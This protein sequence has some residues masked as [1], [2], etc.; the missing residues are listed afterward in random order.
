MDPDTRDDRPSLLVRIL[1]PIAFFWV[2]SCGVAWIASGAKNYPDRFSES[3]LWGGV[4][5]APAVTVALYLFV[6]LVRRLIRGRASSWGALFFSSGAVFGGLAMNLVLFSFYLDRVFPPFYSHGRRLHH[7]AKILAAS[8]QAGA[9]W[10]GSQAIALDVEDGERDAVAAQWRENGSKEHASIAA[11]AHVT[12]DLMAVGAPA[13]IIAAAQ[14]AALDE[15]R[16]AEACYAVA[17]A[18]DGREESPAPFPEAHVRR[19]LAKARPVALAQIAVDALAD[20]ALNEGIA[21]RILARLA[22]RAGTPEL[23][24]LLAQTA[25]DEARHARD[26]WDVIEWCVAEGGDLVRYALARAKEAMPAHLGSPLPPAARSGAWEAWGVQGVSLE[27]AEYAIV[28]RQA[29][30]RLDT[31]L[32]ASGTSEARSAA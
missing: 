8:A 22:K 30:R 1:A 28:R 6:S 2:F 9:G 16:H 27:I 26:S 15:V 4:A 10:I 21:S 32:A 23:S 3:V 7:K 17:R 20:G 18:I 24:Q 12:L 14:R 11:F 19:T 5:G 13:T 25:A 29:Q 31:I